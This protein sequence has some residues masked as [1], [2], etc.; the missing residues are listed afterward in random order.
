MPRPPPAILLATI[1]VLLYKRRRYAHTLSTHNSPPTEDHPRC[2]VNSRSLLNAYKVTV[3]N[4]VEECERFLQSCVSGP[5]R[6]VGLD[7]E[8][9]GPGYLSRNQHPGDD[10]ESEESES[11]DCPVALLQLAFPNGEVAL[12]RLCQ[13]SGIGQTLR[14][15]LTNRRCQPLSPF[16]P[17]YPPLSP[18]L[19]HY[20]PLSPFLPH[21][22]PL[23]PFLP[24]YPLLSP[25]LPHYP[26]LSPFLPHYPLNYNYTLNRF[27][28]F[29]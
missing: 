14:D 17:H 10:C 13:M 11:E 29:H 27:K 28:Y 24:H 1:G 18:F 26:P 6:V 20:P 25:F 16:L 8:W 3:V 19:P 2:H 23:S 7:C 9:R 21:S 4:T 15:L 5:V 22:P 12:V